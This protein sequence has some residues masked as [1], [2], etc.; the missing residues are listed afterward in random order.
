MV[1][2]SGR[3]AAAPFDELPEA[4]TSLPN[5]HEKLILLHGDEGNAAACCLGTC[6]CFEL[7]LRHEKGT[8]ILLMVFPARL[9]EMLQL[10]GRRR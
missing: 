1:L 10:R 5:E 3:L 6:Y 4:L 2:S 9:Q 8:G 7:S